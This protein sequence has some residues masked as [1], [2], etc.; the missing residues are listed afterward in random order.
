M[1]AVQ[2]KANPKLPTKVWVTAPAKWAG[3]SGVRPMTTS[4]DFFDTD[5]KGCG[6]VTFSSY[7]TYGNATK[8]LPQERILEYL[9][10]EI[11]TCIDIK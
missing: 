5:N 11:G 7:H 2:K 1:W 4:F 10:L 9:I 3:G 8:L 6:R